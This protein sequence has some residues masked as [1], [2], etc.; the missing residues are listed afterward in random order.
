M[1]NKALAGKTVFISGASRGIGKAIALRCAQDGANV[2]IAAKTAEPDSRLPGTIHTA[3]QEVV[4]AGGKCLPVA[5]DLRHEQQ[6]ATAVEAA[7]KEFGGIDVLVNNAGVIDLSGT[8]ELQI[9]KYHLMMDVNAKGTFLCIKHCLPYLKKAQN[10]HI[11]NIC[12]PLNRIEN[13]PYFAN[14]P[15]YTVSKFCMTLYTYGLSEELKNSGIAV[16]ALWPK[17]PIW[18]AAVRNLPHL[19]E[20]YR[21]SCRSS[22]I[23]SDAAHLVLSKDPKTF[24]GHFL[25]DEDF[26]REDAGVTDFEKYRATET[27]K[28]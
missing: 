4:E 12:P 9:K 8:D 28:L 13:R 17:K 10:A 22:D 14:G 27:S 1:L 19:G 16:N 18:T 20:K 24:T 2:V 6:I 5:M 23:M 7:A 21:Q 15:A 11:L 26:L 3:A 25:F